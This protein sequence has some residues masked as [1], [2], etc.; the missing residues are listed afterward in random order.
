M[1]PENHQEPSIEVPAEKKPNFEKTEGANEIVASI[2]EEM[3]RSVPEFGKPEEDIFKIESSVGLS[4]SEDSSAIREELKI[5]QTLDDL[6]TQAKI[7]KLEAEKK[8]AWVMLNDHTF[9]KEAFHRVIDKEGYADFLERDSAR[10]SPTGTKHDD[11]QRPTFFPSFAKGAPNLEHYGQADDDNYIL[12]SDRPMFGRGDTN[13][14]TGQVIK[15]RHWAY[16]PLDPK[17]GETLA[18]LSAD[19]IKNVYKKDKQGGLF[20]QEKNTSKN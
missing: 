14:V 20:I 4:S 17:T 2:R 8:I 16:R 3:A 18:E 19:E 1:G 9:N 15:G 6:E 5:D 10:S 12:E 7:L 13:P 11:L